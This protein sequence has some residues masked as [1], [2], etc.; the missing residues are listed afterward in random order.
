[1]IDECEQHVAQAHLARPPFMDTEH[2]EP[3]ALLHLGELVEL[4]QDHARIGV[5][6]ELDHDPHAVAIGFVA[7][8]ADTV[9]TLV[10]D[11]LR[12]PFDETRL[13]H[14]VGNFAHDDRCPARPFVGLDGSQRAHHQGAASGQVCLANRLAAEQLAAGRK[15]RTRNDIQNFLQ[16]QVRL[17]DQRKQRVGNLGEIVRR[18]VGGHPDGDPVRPVDEQVR[19]LR[20]EDFRLFL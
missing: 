16:R 1:M 4:V 15:I 18:N 10:V 12:H 17:V 8:I 14:L 20:G 19:K 2:D 11:Q 6:L 13:V 7:Q 5:A 9:E 3:V